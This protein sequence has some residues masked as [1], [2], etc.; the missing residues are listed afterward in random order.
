MLLSRDGTPDHRN[1]HFIIAK[2]WKHPKCPSADDWIRK[3]WYIC[4]MENYVAIKKKKFLSFAATWME[5]ENIMLSEISQ[6]MKEKHNMTS[7]IYG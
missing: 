3:L 4:S 5:M 1:R 7:L 6:P 2:I